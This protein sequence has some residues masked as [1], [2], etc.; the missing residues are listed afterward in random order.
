MASSTK[1]ITEKRFCGFDRELLSHCLNEE[2]INSILLNAANTILFDEN[3]CH[4]E[5]SSPKHISENIFKKASELIS[6]KLKQH[7][8]SYKIAVARK[9][10]RDYYDL[11]VKKLS[12]GLFNEIKNNGKNVQ[13]A[14]IILHASMSNKIEFKATENSLCIDDRFLSIKAKNIVERIKKSKSAKESSVI[15]KEIA[16][17]LKKIN[18]R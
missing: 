9:L 10:L 18:K 13:K 1:T 2:E 14:K 15:I 17:S 3:L 7:N 6:E 16:D 4:H 5:Y 12:K 8:V 11:F